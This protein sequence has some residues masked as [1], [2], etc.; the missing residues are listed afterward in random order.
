[1]RDRRRAYYGG[2]RARARGIIAR[3]GRPGFALPTAST[4]DLIRP[5]PWSSARCERAKARARVRAANVRTARV[6]RFRG[7]A[8]GIIINIPLP[9]KTIVRAYTTAYG[10]PT[11]RPR[12]TLLRD[13]F[14]FFRRA[15]RMLFSVI[16]EI[17]QCRPCWPVTETER[18]NGRAKKCGKRKKIHRQ[19]IHSARSYN[20]CYT[21]VQ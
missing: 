11:P 3:D 10:S 14:P 2:A 15:R 9:A 7:T 16:S 12:F 5:P 6:R 13:F 1:M 21:A 17:I 18:F 20:Y 8:R 19:P 4:M